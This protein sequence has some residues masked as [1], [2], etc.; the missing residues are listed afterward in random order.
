[1][2][3][4]PVS[5]DPGGDRAYHAARS[6]NGCP[7]AGA[8]SSPTASRSLPRR[9]AARAA[10]AAGVFTSNPLR[11]LDWLLDLWVARIAPAVPE[12]ELHIYA[13]PPSMGSP[14]AMRGGWTR[15][16]RA[17]THSPRHGVR[18]FAPVG[19]DR[20]ADSAGR[21]PG[22]CSIAA[23]PARRSAS[24]SPRRRRWA[25]R[26]WSQP[27]G[28]AP[29]RVIDGV[30]GRVAKDDDGFAAAAIALLRDDELWRPLASRRARNG[31]AD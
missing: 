1:M 13:G 5:S 24:R 23:I 17:P 27:L 2:A 26:P 12:A 28:S 18:R 11:G 8:R 30:T 31:S 20:L 3:A 9:A 25:C 29:E 21:A 7:A 19:R 4:R 6:R 10:A 15:S 14:A 22:S 16:S